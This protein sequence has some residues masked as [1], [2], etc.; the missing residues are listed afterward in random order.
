MGERFTAQNKPLF[1]ADARP[2]RPSEV[3]AAR[4]TSSARLQA[5]DALRELFTVTALPDRKLKYFDQ[6]P[7]GLEGA[8]K[9]GEK[10]LLY[11]L[12]EDMVKK[13]YRCVVARAAPPLPPAPTPGETAAREGM[14]HRT[15][16]SSCTLP[17]A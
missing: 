10:R 14:R 4:L 11:W 1:Q 17:H 2:C 15:S 13:R 3:G 7:L 12:V 16:P 6:Q 9:V 5:L 8:G